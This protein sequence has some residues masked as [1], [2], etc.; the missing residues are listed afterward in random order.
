[1]AHRRSSPSFNENPAL[2]ARAVQIN[3]NADIYKNVQIKSDVENTWILKFPIALTNLGDITI[4]TGTKDYYLNATVEEGEK[5]SELT[6][7]KRYG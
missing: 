3:W 7:R 6:L 1:M 5:T 2:R 4:K